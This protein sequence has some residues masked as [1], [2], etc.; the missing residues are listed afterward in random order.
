M[1]DVASETLIDLP[2][3]LEST[4]FLRTF[5]HCLPFLLEQVCITGLVNPSKI[6]EFPRP[7]PP[8]ECRTSPLFMIDSTLF[9]SLSA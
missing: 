1:F 5:T 9:A 6:V 3:S 2:F 7:R 4:F 8:K